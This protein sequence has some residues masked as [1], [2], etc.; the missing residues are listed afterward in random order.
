MKL[1]IVESPNKCAK[2][3]KYLGSDYRVAASV[4]HVRSIPKK[5]MNIDIGNGFLPVFEISSDKKKVVKDLKE[6]AEKADEIILATDPDREGEAISWHIYDLLS[7]KDQKKCKRVTFNAI[8]K[9]AVLNALKKARTIDMNIVDAQKA[10]QVLDRLI[11]YTL[12]PLLWYKVESKTSAGRVQ[13]IAVKIVSL[14]E[15]E[16]Q[17]FKPEDFWYIDALLK[18]KEGEFS[19]RVV[20]KDK[21]NRYLDEKLSKEDYAKLQKATY[22][23]NKIDRKQKKVEAFPPFDTSSLQTAASSIFNWSAKQTA[24]LSQKL[25]ESGLVSY[26]R[27]DSFNIAKEAVDQVRAFLS[28]NVKCEYIPKA[29]NVF[30]KNAKSSSQE[31]HECI[32]PTDCSNVGNDLS[33]DEKKLYKLIRERFVACQMAPMVVDTVTYEIKA[34]TGHQLIAKGQT[35]RFDGWTKV[36]KYVSKKDV[37]LPCVEDGEK[38][39]LKKLDKIKGTTKPP[40]R[41][42]EGSLIKKMEDEGVGRPST[43]PAIMENIQQRGYVKKIDKKGMLQATELG[44]KVFEYLEDNFKDFIM[45]IHYTATLESDL[46]IIEDGKK[47]YCEVVSCVYDMMM[48]EVTKARGEQMPVPKGSTKCLCCD[49]GT[50]VEKHGKFGIFY[51]CDQ[52]PKCKSIFELNEEGIFVKKEYKSAGKSSGRPCPECEKAGRKGVLVKRNNKKDNSTFYGCS[53]YPKCK[54]TESDSIDDLGVD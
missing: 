47:T 22:K 33:T 6:L 45:D 52:Y 36:Y 19:A 37:T 23:I 28:K 27:T 18:A 26:I 50:I 3:R 29:P 42:S 54:N 15:K 24:S 13:S 17:N 41:Y 8:T 30:K 20:T 4:G 39:D 9:D 7:K 25:Y 46:D 51:A 5:G 38:L 12:S 14:R 34:S 43:Y 53:A 44:I 31:A 32:R 1:F 2:L 16:I 21:D 49:S 48:T 40:P 10:R 35:I 11:G